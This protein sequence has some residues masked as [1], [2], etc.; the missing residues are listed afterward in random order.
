MMKN[1]RKVYKTLVNITTYIPS[2]GNFLMNNARDIHEKKIDNAPKT[3][4]SLLNQGKQKKIWV[5]DPSKGKWL[6]E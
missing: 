3:A 5:N 4:L 6:K 2:L 1:F